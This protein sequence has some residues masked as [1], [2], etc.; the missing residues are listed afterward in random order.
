MLGSRDGGIHWAQEMYDQA[1][2]VREFVKW[3]YMLAR[4]VPAAVPPSGTTTPTD[5]APA[6]AAVEQLADLPA[7]ARFPVFVTASSGMEPGTAELLGQLCDEF[8]IGCW[9]RGRAV[10]TSI[11]VIPCTWATIWGRWRSTRTF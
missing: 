7:G 8:A 6:A 2:M 4:A 9:R 5:A 3:D 11:R 1:S 10:T